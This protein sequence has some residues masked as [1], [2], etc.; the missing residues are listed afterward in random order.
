MWNRLPFVLL[1][2]VCVIGC[3]QS[4][5]PPESEIPNIPPVTE[6]GA[7]PEDGALPAK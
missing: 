2:C 4:Y 3:S 5:E 1:I 6:R 7:T